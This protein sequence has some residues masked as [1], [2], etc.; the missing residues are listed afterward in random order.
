MK[1]NN[2][3]HFIFIFL[4]GLSINGQSKKWTLKECV[5]YAID[6]NISIKQSELDSKFAT[7]DKKEAI[8]S[9]LPSINSSANHSWNVGLNQDITTGILRN[10]TTQ[11]TSLG[12][13]IGVDIYKG[14]QNQYIL[15]KS[16]LSIVA[17]KFQL[18]KMQEDVALNVTNAFLQVL[19]DRENLKVQQDQLEINK[20]H[21]RCYSRNLIL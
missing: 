15:R 12:A 19:F 20:K 5:Q 13:S 1:K 8:G 10:Q 4:V 14:L 3:I 21:F 11:F 18:Q 9:F 17:A 6:N 16:N 7:I 2:L